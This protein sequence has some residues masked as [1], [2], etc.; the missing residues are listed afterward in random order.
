MNSWGVTRYWRY[1]KEKMATRGVR[2]QI[3]RRRSD[4]A[5]AP[6]ADDENARDRIEGA[7]GSQSGVESLRDCATALHRAIAPISES[8][9][10]KSQKGGRNCLVA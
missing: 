7:D 1:S 6:A 2:R 4:A 5:L 8:H 10:Q 9:A 3:R